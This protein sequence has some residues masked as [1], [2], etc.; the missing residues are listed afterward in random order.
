MSLQKILLRVIKHAFLPFPVLADFLTAQIIMSM[1]IRLKESEGTSWCKTL[2]S[3]GGI[4]KNRLFISCSHSA[5][6]SLYGQPYSLEATCLRLNCFLFTFQILLLSS[7]TISCPVPRCSH[8]AFC[9]LAS[10]LLRVANAIGP[11]ATQNGAQRT[12]QN[13]C[14]SSPQH[15][16][17]VL[18]LWVGLSYFLTP[19][20]AV[21][22]LWLGSQQKCVI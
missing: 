4:R 16:L 6:K 19:F 15:F 22:A 17:G 14:T 9:P 7:Q 5:W 12:R 18:H 8:L 3:G 10:E 11:S 1:T 20:V 2:H 21:V 13:G